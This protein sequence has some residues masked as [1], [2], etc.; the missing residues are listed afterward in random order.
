MLNPGAN[1][2]WKRWHPDRFA[3]LATHLHERR[4]MTVL[5]NGSPAEADLFDS[6]AAQTH[7]PVIALPRLGIRIGSLKAILRR[8]FLIVTNYGPTDHRWAPIPTQPQAPEIKL[9]AD[10]TLP[11]TESANDHPERCAIA[12]VPFEVVREAVDRVLAP[13]PDL[14]DSVTPQ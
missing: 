13:S 11:D 6:I 12:K 1:K 4:G 7:S 5:L 2:D 14:S 3:A 8:C 9:L 10:P